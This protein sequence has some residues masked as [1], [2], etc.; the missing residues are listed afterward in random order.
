MSEHIQTIQ[1]ITSIA[2]IIG[3]VFLVYNKL[4]KPGEDSGQRLDK[5]ETSCELKHKIIDEN[6]LLIKE[7]HLRHIENDISEIKQAITRINTILEERE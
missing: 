3:M 7:N 6:L 1:F 4:R 5:L 2:T